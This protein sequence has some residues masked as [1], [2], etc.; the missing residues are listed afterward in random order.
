MPVMARCINAEKV[1][2]A[3]QQRGWTQSRLADELKVSDQAVT[4]WL[5]GKHFPRSPVLL[6]LA[7]LLELGP[8]DL[9]RDDDPGCPIVAFRRKGGAR[10]AEDH[11]ARAVGIG[12]MLRPLVPYLDDAPALRPRIELPSTE[13]GKL[14]AMAMETRNRLG[15]GESDA[16]GYEHLIEEFG[17]AGAVLVPVLWGARKRHE[18]ALHILLPKECATFVF[19]NLDTRIEDFKFWMAHELA[20][21]YTPE[22]AGTDEGEDFAD[23][24]AGTLLFPR[25]CAGAAYQEAEGLSAR[26]QI[27]VLEGYA[28]QHDI[29][30]YTVFLQM[31]QYAASERLPA[32]RI[33]EEKIHQSRNRASGDLVS[34]I[35]F[36]AEAPTPEQYIQSCKEAFR[37]GF[38]EALTRMIG[39]R[40]T[41]AGYLQQ[42]IDSSVHDARALHASLAADAHPA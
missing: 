8:K 22:L 12:K 25:A 39:D 38:F 30:L 37:S 31:Q 10:T 18:N 42:I 2:E 3:L 27:N 20:H 17:R 14:Q 4:H 32:L 26:L 5:Q 34:Q 6:K 29:S 28:R 36:G 16:L 35:I 9:I 19:L 11:I 41:E 40:G 33:K 23:A 1:R 21:V 13:A 24:F 15:M 7:M